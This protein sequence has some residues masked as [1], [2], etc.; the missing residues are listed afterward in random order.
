MDLHTIQ[1]TE[2]ERISSFL[3]WANWRITKEMRENKLLESEFGEGA[4]KKEKKL[5][6]TDEERRKIL[7]D[8]QGYLDEGFKVS[9]AAEKAGVHYKTYY[10]WKKSISNNTKD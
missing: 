4:H 2:A 3:E 9:T 5:R 8:I 6:Y 10:S 7:K 1:D